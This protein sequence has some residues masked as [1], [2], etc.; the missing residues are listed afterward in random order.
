M[1]RRQRARLVDRRTR[2]LV[3]RSGV[4][5]LLDRAAS[6]ALPIAINVVLGSIAYA[7]RVLDQSRNSTE[8]IARADI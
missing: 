4:E 1:H 6:R 7:V 5:P 2:G 8:R 3:M